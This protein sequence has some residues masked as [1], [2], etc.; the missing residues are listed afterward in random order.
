MEDTV[1]IGLELVGIAMLLAHWLFFFCEEWMFL[2]GE[3]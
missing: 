1:L 3:R 2:F